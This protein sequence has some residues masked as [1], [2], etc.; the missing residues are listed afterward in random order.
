MKNLRLLSVLLL[1]SG[2]FFI[3]AGHTK[4]LSELNQNQEEVKQEEAKPKPTEKNI[5][6]Q[7]TTLEFWDNLAIVPVRFVDRDKKDKKEDRLIAQFES[8]HMFERIEFVLPADLERAFYNVD[9]KWHEEI[10]RREFLKKFKKDFWLVI[11]LAAKD[12]SENNVI[13]QVSQ[14]KKMGVLE[15]S[16]GQDPS[17]ISKTLDTLAFWHNIKLR[18]VV[19]YKVNSA[20]NKAYWFFI[21][22]E[23]E[24][25]PSDQDTG[26]I[27]LENGKSR[28]SFVRFHDGTG[29]L[30]IDRGYVILDKNSTFFTISTKRSFIK[31]G[32]IIGSSSISFKLVG[33]DYFLGKALTLPWL[34]F[35][36]ATT[37]KLLQAKALTEE[38]NGGKNKKTNEK[39]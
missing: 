35:Y 23:N 9:G 17:D 19:F 2:H 24:W 33:R 11:Y 13:C 15:T 38:N 6:R 4:N 18:K 16:F 22:P 3:Q 8:K 10:S 7:K 37:K 32:G 27:I 39:K 5:C 34:C 30:I 29:G 20:E 25:L 28:P 31:I 21:K 36:D 12:K 14:I 26:N 1:V